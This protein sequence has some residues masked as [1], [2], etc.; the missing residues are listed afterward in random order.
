MGLIIKVDRTTCM[1]SGQ[2]V[3][4]APGVFSQDEEA[5]A[6]VVHPRGEPE[7]KIITA[8]NG[9]PV[10]AISLGVDGEKVEAHHLADRSGGACLKGVSLFEELS[11]DHD[12]LRASMVPIFDSIGADRSRPP[13]GCLDDD[14]GLSTWS[15]SLPPRTPKVPGESTS[16][17][18]RPRGDSKATR[19][20]R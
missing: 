15:G 6:I 4:W 14:D 8:V 5:I 3:H 1:G 17:D 19:R 2:C 16:R 7:E 12:E 18:P 20:R 11:N 10:E 13:L 9:C